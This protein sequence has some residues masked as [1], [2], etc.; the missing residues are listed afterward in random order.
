M[1]WSS[2]LGECKECSPEKLN[3]ERMKRNLKTLR[4]RPLHADRR[5]QL[6][7]EPPMQNRSMVNTFYNIDI[8]LEWLL[9]RLGWWIAN[10]WQ[11]SHDDRRSATLICSRLNL[12]TLLWARRNQEESNNDILY[13]LE[14]YE[15]FRENQ[16]SRLKCI[17]DQALYYPW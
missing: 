15:A 17:W 5:R 3:K 8:V 12:A 1:G 7:G 9:R 10:P 4:H 11:K 13:W 6:G 14:L 16:C 2:T